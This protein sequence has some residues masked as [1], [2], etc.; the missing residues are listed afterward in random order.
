MLGVGKS[1]ETNVIVSALKNSQSQIQ[2]PFKI[3]TKTNKQKKK[4]KDINRFIIN[5]EIPPIVINHAKD[6]L[7]KFY[8]LHFPW[9]IVGI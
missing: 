4:N 6:C 2:V 1:R 5:L 8:A 7:A 9:H 3:L